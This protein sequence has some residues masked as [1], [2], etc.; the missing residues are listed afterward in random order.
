MVTDAELL[1]RYREASKDIRLTVSE[2]DT[3]FLE[4]QGDGLKL[5]LACSPE[6]PHLATLA[7][8]IRAD[9]PFTTTTAA[10][11]ANSVNRRVLGARVVVIGELSFVV[12][13]S[14]IVAA[15]DTLPDPDLLQAILPRCIEMLRCA[16]SLLDEE[17]EFDT[18]TGQLSLTVDHSSAASLGD[19]D[20]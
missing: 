18:I 3:G 12:Q 2:A 16:A 9:A 8:P 7:V 11:V 4:V 14:V 1:E 10:D 19:R 5:L 6:S 17:I 20:E 15:V 13:A